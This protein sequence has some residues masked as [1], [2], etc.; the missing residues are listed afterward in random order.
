MSQRQ[1]R[2]RQEVRMLAASLHV[3]TCSLLSSSAWFHL[4]LPPG[5]YSRLPLT[6]SHLLPTAL[7]PSL[8]DGG[9]QEVI[10]NLLP[11]FS[12]IPTT[13][14]SEIIE[15]GRKDDDVL[16]EPSNRLK[17]KCW[18]RISLFLPER[19]H[20]STR[21]LTFLYFLDSGLLVRAPAVQQRSES[22]PLF[23]SRGV[24]VNGT[25]EGQSPHLVFSISW[26]IIWGNVRGITRPFFLASH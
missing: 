13:K 12:M 18:S 17:D 1:F 23:L 14:A 8:W 20:Q 25:T 7:K 22:T 11:C 16:P 24:N 4:S 9:C 5:K 15:Q 26:M 6:L 10:D 21:H 2:R 3:D 19:T